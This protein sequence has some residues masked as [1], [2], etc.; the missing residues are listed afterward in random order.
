MDLNVRQYNNMLLLLKIECVLSIKKKEA[1]FLKMPRIK[2]SSSLILRNSG[3]T[4]TTFRYLL[5]VS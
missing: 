4:D 1:L 2:K 5:H 3:K